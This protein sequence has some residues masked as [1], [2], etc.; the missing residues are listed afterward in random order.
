MVSKIKYT[1][2]EILSETFNGIIW[3]IKTDATQPLM[4]IE[5]R[6]PESKTAYWTML[7]WETGEILYKELELDNSWNY[8]LDTVHEGVLFLYSYV[9]P[10]MPVRKGVRAIGQSGKTLWQNFNKILSQTVPGGIIVADTSIL[11]PYYEII[12][13]KTGLK[14]NE[15][16]NTLENIK[17][18]EMY[19]PEPAILPPFISKYFTETEGLNEP[20]YHL[21]FNGLD[22]YSFHVAVN[23]KY[24]QLL[25]AA[26]NEEVQ[27]LE[28]LERNIPKMNIDAFFIQ[29]DKLVA[30]RNNKREI[31]IYL[32]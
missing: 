7:N 29:Q 22:L 14:I 9:S 20:F 19:F 27:H 5:T 24:H 8:S 4:G 3:Q 28:F 26:K 12:D 2:K 10:E 18:Y 6:D 11:P 25:V 32:L 15:Q 17:Q 30:I 16:K 31:V 1:L 13:V 21:L 23:G